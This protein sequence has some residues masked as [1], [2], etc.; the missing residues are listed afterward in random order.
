MYRT[1]CLP[2][3][4][5]HGGTLP[6][7]YKNGFPRNWEGSLPLVVYEIKSL[8]LYFS[9]TMVKQTSILSVLLF[10]S[11]YLLGVNAHYKI[12]APPPRGSLSANMTIAPCGGFLD[13]NQT[14]LSNFPI[15]KYFQFYLL[16]HSFEIII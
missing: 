9:F 13:V 7:I 5:L 15:R 14:S 4:V 12:I 3:V 11:L 6:V 1:S 16:K 2:N 8:R 10:L